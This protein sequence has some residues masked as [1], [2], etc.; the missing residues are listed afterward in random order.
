MRLSIMVAI[1]Q[2]LVDCGA[3]GPETKETS[4]GMCTRRH[5]IQFFQKYSIDSSDQLNLAKSSVY[6]ILTRDPYTCL[7]IRI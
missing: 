5:V 1:F 2:C 7:H 3:F 6:G 4:T